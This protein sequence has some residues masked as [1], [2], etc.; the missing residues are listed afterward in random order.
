MRKRRI[1][2]RSPDEAWSE[3]ECVSIADCFGAIVAKLGTGSLQK[4]K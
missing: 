3:M 4:P 2:P 1:L